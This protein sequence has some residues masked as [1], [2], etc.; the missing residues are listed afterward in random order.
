VIVLPALFIVDANVLID[1][2]RTDPTFLALVNRHVGTV[3]VASVVLDKVDQLSRQDADRLGLAIVEPD[4]ELA[5]DA[6][7]RARTGP[8]A[9]DDW[10]CLLLAQARK[11]TC[12]TNDRRLRGECATV[13]VDVLWGLQLLG[14]LVQ[15]GVLPSR[16][17]V[18]AAWAIHRTNPRFIP[19]H[20]VKKFAASLA[21]AKPA[22]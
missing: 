5:A 3:H 15:K 22:K 2:C 12:V 17:A 18:A 20:L 14:A 16:D 8:L 13:G 11:W 6:A 7:L 21:R 1:F 9:F 10:V 19:E 4:L